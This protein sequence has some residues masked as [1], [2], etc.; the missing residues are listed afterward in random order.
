MHVI[1]QFFSL[2]SKIIIRT[3][4]Y[5]LQGSTFHIIANLL[6][7]HQFQMVSQISFQFRLGHSSVPQKSQQ[8]HLTCVQTLPH[9]LQLCNTLHILSVCLHFSQF[10]NFSVVIQ[11]IFIH[12]QIN[13]CLSYSLDMC[14][15]VDYALVSMCII[16]MME[17]NWILE[18]S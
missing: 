7:I 1:S 14:P 11:L 2:F 3:I 9:T 16:V 8:L 18:N 10:I 5:P 13:L 15:V 4:I 12:L 17:D 6:T